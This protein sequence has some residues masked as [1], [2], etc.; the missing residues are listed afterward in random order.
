[1]SIGFGLFWIFNY[2]RTA[3]IWITL[4]SS[5]AYVI[6]GM[7]HHALRGELRWQIIWEYTVVAALVG[8]TVVFLL[9][10]A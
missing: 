8:L 2:N 4:G 1:L 9:M 7:I 5:T 6:W 10:R 3:Q